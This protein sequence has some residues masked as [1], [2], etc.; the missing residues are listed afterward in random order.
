MYKSYLR[1]FIGFFVTIILI[2]ILIILLFGGG[3]KS[4]KNST[5][6]TNSDKPA[7]LQDIADTDSA[8]RMTIAGS[9]RANQDY[10]EVKI[11]SSQSS[12]ELQIIRGYENHVIRSKDYSNNLSAYT[13][14]LRALQ[15]AGYM[16][17]DDSK[18]LANDTGYCALGQRYIFEIIQDNKVIQRYWSSSCGSSAP[19]TYLGQTA[20]TMQL[21]EMQIPDYSDLTSDIDF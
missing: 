6:T 9:V 2:I 10:Y 17:G 8:V 18:A 15:Q 4:D 7:S 21:F 19:H 16:N 5:G 3:K 14:F 11:T 13:V 20:L 12:N 1:Y